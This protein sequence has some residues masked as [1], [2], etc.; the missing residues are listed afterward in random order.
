MALLSILPALFLGSLYFGARE[1]G[2]RAALQVHGLLDSSAFTIGLFCP[3]QAHPL[4]ISGREC[5]CV[6]VVKYM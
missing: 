3:E 4:E 1:R 5:V 2:Q 6:H